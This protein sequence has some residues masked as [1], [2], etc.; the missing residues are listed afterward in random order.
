MTREDKLGVLYTG[1]AAALTLTIIFTILYVAIAL[2]RREQFNQCIINQPLHPVD[3]D[4]RITG[5]GF[6]ASGTL[7]YLI[8]Y[9]GHNRG[10]NSPCK[11][12]RLITEIEY[13][14]FCEPQSKN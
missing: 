8:W 10:D 4:I 6:F 1:V 3:C 9:E 2:D 12:K 11:V 7:T 13:N 14:R 5:A